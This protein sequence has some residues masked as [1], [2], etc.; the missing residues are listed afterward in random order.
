L[1]ISDRQPPIANR[2]PP[3][4][5][6]QAASGEAQSP[7]PKAQGPKPKAS[8]FHWAAGVLAW[9]V[10]GACLWATHEQLGYWRD[11][12][13]LFTHTVEVTGD[14]YMAQVTL[15]YGYEH[16]GRVAEALAH[17]RT[18]IALYPTDRLAY[19]AL[20]ELTGK[21]G[22]WADAA[23]AYEAVLQIDPH[24]A[25]AH[26]GL[27]N[28]LPHLGRKAEA[29][30]HLEAALQDGSNSPELLNNL[31]WGLATSADSRLRN[32]PRA[33]QLA[34]QACALT[35]D[36]KTIMIGTLAAAYAEAGR[37][38]EAVATAQKACASATA[39]GETNLLAANQKLL[40]LYQQ[41]QA[42]HEAEEEIK[43]SNSKSQ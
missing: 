38:A 33:V 22:A 3:I 37:F 4:S 30:G 6:R 40:N 26:L 23:A 27:A 5:N 16:A 15:G 9:V 7:K 35:Y 24:A 1:Q 31:A 17:Y 8:F 41:H 28:A 39:H 13:A 10:P 19:E 11:T 21:S 42:W 32:G 29:V 20:G 12:V 2:Q 34:E 43:D 18:A 36:Q 14:N 25:A